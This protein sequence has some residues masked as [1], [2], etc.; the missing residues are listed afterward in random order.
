MYMKF[1]TPG[2]FDLRPYG[3]QDWWHMMSPDALK[4]LD[5]V[6][7]R[8]GSPIL[9][10]PHRG[11]LG[12]H[13]G[14]SFSDHNVDRW[15]EVRVADV[16]PNMDQTPAAAQKFVDAC[17]DVGVTALGVYPHWKNRHGQLQVGFHIGYR[18]ERTDNPATWGMIRYR[19]RGIQHMVP[20]SQAVALAG[21]PPRE[22]R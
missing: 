13:L 9:I 18:P 10:S 3:G 17:F 19:P 5:R 1:F 6:R 8:H 14:A 2:E 22:L 11:A 16:F 12:R 20:L 4:L 15:G 21:Q 7:G